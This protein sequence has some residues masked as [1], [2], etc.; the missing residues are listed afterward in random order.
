MKLKQELFKQ[1]EKFVNNR[2]QTI[3]EI[4]SSNQKALQSETKSSAGDKHETGRAMLQLEMEKAGQQ[5]Q[6]VLQMKETLAK[7]DVSK[8][9]TIAHLGSLVKTNQ[10]TYFLSISAGQLVVANEQYFAVSVSSPIGNLLLGKKGKDSFVFSG[11]QITITCV[12]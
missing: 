8:N 4:I 5:L 9:S 2:L 3:Q 7:I 6:G 1:C 11:K 10:A 12:N